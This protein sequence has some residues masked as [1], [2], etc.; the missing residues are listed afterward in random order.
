MDPITMPLLVRTTDVG[1]GG[2]APPAAPVNPA[3]AA[4]ARIDAA[5]AAGLRDGDPETGAPIAP[6][7]GTPPPEGTPPEG[8]PPADAELDPDKL[9]FEN[10]NYRDGK[11]IEQQLR[12][13]RERYKPYADAVGALPEDQRQVALEALQNPDVLGF[14][15]GMNPNDRQVLLGIYQQFLTDPAAGAEAFRALADQIAPAGTPASPSG[16]PPA[17][18]PPADGAPPDP[19]A[20]M[21]RAEFDEYN[22]QQAQTAEQAKAEQAAVATM[23]AEMKTLGYDPESS[24][25]VK[26]DEADEVI[27]QAAH[28]TGGDLKAADAVLKARRQAIIDGYVNGKKADA[29]TPGTPETGQSPSGST[30][31]G[32]VDPRA[33]ME[34]RLE[35]NLGPDPQ[36]RV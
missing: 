31:P 27:W 10:L 15:H 23:Y 36:A 32:K 20:P 14:V 26:K 17:G 30:P 22:R 12:S 29:G 19:D 13:Q 6:A 4:N 5:V 1:G 21:T 33:A 7:D 18:A 9:D 24:D 25:P 28:R 35:A 8:T 11:K 16:T 34:A 3:D 2:G